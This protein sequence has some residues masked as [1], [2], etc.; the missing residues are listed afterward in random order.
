MIQQSITVRFPIQIDKNKVIFMIEGSIAENTKQNVQCQ[1]IRSIE[2]E[3]EFIIWGDSNKAFYYA[4]MAAALIIQLDS[5][6]P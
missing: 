3:N 2:N 4:G 5:K 1:F 6:K